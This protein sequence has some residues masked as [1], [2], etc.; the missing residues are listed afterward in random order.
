MKYFDQD[1]I[2]LH[3]HAPKIGIDFLEG[4]ERTYTKDEILEA[5]ALHTSLLSSLDGGNIDALVS[6]KHAGPVSH[7]LL[8]ERVDKIKANKDV[9]SPEATKEIRDTLILAVSTHQAYAAQEIGMLLRPL[10]GHSAPHKEIMMEALELGARKDNANGV[11]E[12]V[13]SCSKPDAHLTAEIETMVHGVMDDEH[14][15]R[16]NFSPL[17]IIERH[18]SNQSSGR[19]WQPS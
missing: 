4:R 19:G 9:S 6:Q 8:N 11:F 5:K 2:N 15:K 17:A 10:V 1:F 13:L 18:K 14:S 12:R 7:D 16:G 3:L